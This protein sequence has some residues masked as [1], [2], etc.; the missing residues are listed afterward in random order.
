MEYLS[1]LIEDRIQG[2][3]DRAESRDSGRRIGA[4]R[5]V[6]DRPRGVVA[7][8]AAILIRVRRRVA[9]TPGIENDSGEE[10]RLG[11]AL[12]APLSLNILIEYSF[13][14]LR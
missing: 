14:V 1:R 8:A 12:L 6:D 11:R 13:A 5:L 9:V 10:T 2:I 3:Q 7:I 4:F